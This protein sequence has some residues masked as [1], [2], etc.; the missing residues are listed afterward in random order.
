MHV[1]TT[2]FIYAMVILYLQAYSTP[3]SSWLWFSSTLRSVPLYIYKINQKMRIN[4]LQS[5]FS[6]YESSFD[7]TTHRLKIHVSLFTRH[8]ELVLNRVKTGNFEPLKSVGTR[9]VKKFDF[10]A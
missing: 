9:V 3:F 2:E 6:G 4:L 8:L 10:T 1:P 7:R 5:N